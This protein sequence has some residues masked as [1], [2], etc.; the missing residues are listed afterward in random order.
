MQASRGIFLF[1]LLWPT[2]FAQ[3]FNSSFKI[4][5]TNCGCQ[6]R[7]PKVTKLLHVN[8]TWGFL[9]TFP[10][11]SSLQGNL[12]RGIVNWTGADWSAAFERVFF[13]FISTW[14]QN[15]LLQTMLAIYGLQLWNVVL[16][17]KKSKRMPFRTILLHYFKNVL[18]RRE[19]NWN[20]LTSN[21]FLVNTP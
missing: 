14:N 1:Y 20:F 17:K 18:L 5:G 11:L 16:K 4:I 21:G 19:T 9:F 15:H 8:F 3:I 13:F 10:L 2:R 7:V 12:F 6:I